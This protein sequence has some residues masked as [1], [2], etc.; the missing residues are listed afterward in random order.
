MANLA[1]TQAAID[2]LLL[3]VATGFILLMQAG[4]ALVET[5]SVRS[6]NSKNILIKNMFDC[7]AGAIAFWAVGFAFAFGQTGDQGR[8]IGNNGSYFFA[9][10]LNTDDGSN[11]WILWA[12][13][14]SFAATSATIVSGSLA[15]RTM[16]PAYMLFSV[17][18]TGF[19]YPV[20][21]SWTW[22]GGWLGDGSNP[23]NWGFHDFAG[24]GIVHMVG[25]VA[26][27]VG[28]AVIGPRHGK[29]KDQARKRNIKNEP[30][31]EAILSDASLGSREDIENWLENLDNDKEF[32]GNSPPF[33]VVGTII[34]LVSWL[35]FNGGSTGSMFSDSTA[36]STPK[37]IVVTILSGAAGGLSA[38]FLKTRVMGSYSEK[39]RY[40]VGSLCN[41]ILAGLVSI[42]GVCDRVD[43][44]AAFLIGLLGG[45]IYVLSCKLLDILNIDDP[46]EA[47]PVHGFCGIWG[48]IAVG[49]FDTEYGLISS[50]EQ[51]GHFF[52][53]QLLGCL[54]IVAWV[55]VLSLAF[56]L[57][58]KALRM[59]RVPLIEEVIGLDIAEMG[60]QAKI[61]AQEK[62]IQR[63]ASI[64]GF[65]GPA[66]KTQ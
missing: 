10:D 51:K 48:L 35:F 63:R 11:T 65:A 38:A 17:L 31:Y 47:S 52:G 56:F 12:F 58:T 2:Q 39:N 27:F 61:T 28:A 24:T 54:I 19:I 21:V 50:N 44:W 64:S 20:V 36:Q 62:I 45:I 26:G 46:I 16:L 53:I 37:I 22:G 3:V 23:N 30:E 57:P 32:A 33:V 55:A 8:F 60:T 14:F 25:G 15:E 29:E 13:Q 34:L 6:K 43:P 66:G 49:I 5:G 41:G 1:E 42:T 9:A 7:C 4:F 59:L 18:M 40:D